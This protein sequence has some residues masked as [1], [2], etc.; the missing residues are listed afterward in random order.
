MEKYN[1]VYDD[2]GRE[3]S[4]RKGYCRDCVVRALSILMADIIGELSDR[5]WVYDECYN[6]LASKHKVFRPHA[7]RTARRGICNEAWHIVFA[8]YGL[9]PIQ[10]PPGRRLTVA[11][12]GERYGD[13]VVATERHL[14][15]FIRGNLHDTWDP[16]QKPRIGCRKVTEVWK[17]KVS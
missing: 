3:A 1:F 10:L 2:G 6:M 15:A 4:G 14:S 5:G 8:E 7:A 17:E 12:A 9:E 11:E 13:C 16:R